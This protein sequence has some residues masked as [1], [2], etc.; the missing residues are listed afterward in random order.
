MVRSI[1]NKLV[2]FALKIKRG[3]KQKRA[4]RRAHF[5]SIP[6]HEAFLLEDR[7]TLEAKQH[8]CER[9]AYAQLRYFPNLDDPSTYNEKILWLA[10]HY[11][12]PLIATLTDKHEVKGFIS[13]KLG[14]G[15]TAKSFGVFSNV[16]DIDF[17]ALPN[18]FVLK[19]TAGW[20]SKH[21]IIVRDKRTC[22]L[23]NI[24]ASIAAWLYP[25]N[26]YYYNNL[27]IT[28]E[29]ISPRI[30]AEEY[31]DAGSGSNEKGASAPL[32]DY[33]LYC[34]DGKATLALIVRNRGGKNEERTFISLEDWRVLPISRNKASVAPN[35]SRPAFMDEMIAD[36]EKLSSGF[37]LV[38]VDFYCLNERLYV[39]E[40]TFSPGLFLRINPFEWDLKLGELIDLEKVKL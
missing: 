22:D 25:W 37:P 9:K 30:L 24:K 14:E 1:G 21:V 10:L 34:F 17:D 8:Y 4:Q 2:N 23:N 28:D 15:H 20:G 6:Q 32:I 26:T 18:S 7:L 3:I 33:K 35:I 40:M 19:S 36:A 39:G 12:N 31:L 29:K 5:K 38:R 13:E 27:C 11:K 16:N